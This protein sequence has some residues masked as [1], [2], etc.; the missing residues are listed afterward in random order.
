MRRQGP[1]QTA[2]PQVGELS[3]HAAERQRACHRLRAPT[4]WL[5][6]ALRTS[7]QLL[8]E[9]TLG[10]GGVVVLTLTP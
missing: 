2:R 7:A 1:E 5:T 4:A 3:W 9:L 8:I 6:C 10:T